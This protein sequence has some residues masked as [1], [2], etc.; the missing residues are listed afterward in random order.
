MLAELGRC[1]NPRAILLKHHQ[2][3]LTVAATMLELGSWIIKPVLGLRRSR[4]VS[5][6]AG[7]NT[8]F[9]DVLLT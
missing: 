8:Y 2:K 3:L 9:R 1:L 7:N 4:T 6:I 5:G